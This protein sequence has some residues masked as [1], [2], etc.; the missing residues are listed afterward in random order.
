MEKEE[1]LLWAFIKGIGSILGLLITVAAEV[2]SENNKKEFNFHPTPVEA[3]KDGEIDLE[4]Y[5]KNM[6]GGD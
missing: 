3:Y 2:F 6:C 4:E 5:T 1:S